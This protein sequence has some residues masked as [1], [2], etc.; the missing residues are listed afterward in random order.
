MNFNAR[1]KEYRRTGK[2]TF[3]STE[4]IMVGFCFPEFYR[5][6]VPEHLQDRPLEAFFTILDQNQ[7][8]FVNDHFDTKSPLEKLLDIQQEDSK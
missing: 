5:Q 6:L 2:N 1:I 3:S 8:T 7:R 4:A